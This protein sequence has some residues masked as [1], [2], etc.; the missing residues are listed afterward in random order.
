MLGPNVAVMPLTMSSAMAENSSNGNKKRGAVMLSRVAILIYAAAAYLLAVAN[1]AYFVGFLQNFHV[2]KGINDGIPGSVWS[3]VII[4]V[5]LVWL[6]G[7]HHSVTARTWFKG[8]WTKFVP[9]S[10]ERA[11]YLY[12]TAIMTWVLVYFWQPVTI[13]V[14]QV[15]NTFTFW[16]IIALYL[17]AWLAMFSATLPIGHFDFFGLA[18]AW[19]NLRNKPK[20]DSAF[21]ASWLYAVIRHP[22]SLGWILVPWLTPHMTVGQLCFAF[23]VLS[24]I[25]V[26]TIAEEADLIDELGET[27]RAYC[28]RVPAFIPFTKSRRDQG[29]Q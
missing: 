20:P 1:S 24:Y 29:S 26:A 12:M 16:T 17:T 18:Q 22:I 15:E 19:R 4:N 7:F 9:P 27:Y 6:F 8:W 28:N 3:S 23:G 2:P 25:I 11:T 5:G 10:M 21:T 14:W 13:T